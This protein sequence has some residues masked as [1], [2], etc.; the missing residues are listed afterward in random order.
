MRFRNE[1]VLD[2]YGRKKNRGRYYPRRQVR[3]LL[4][5]LCLEHNNNVGKSWV[6]LSDRAQ[7]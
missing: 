5:G 4:A 2:I 1:R 7:A 3:F 6:S